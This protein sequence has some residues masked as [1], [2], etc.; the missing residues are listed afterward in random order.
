MA[1][2]IRLFLLFVVCVFLYA[3][4]F[5]LD[6]GSQDGVAMM[7]PAYI[8]L[9]LAEVASGIYLIVALIRGAKKNVR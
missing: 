1:Q 8:I 3:S 4:T 5:G 2:A 6:E 7:F 9:L